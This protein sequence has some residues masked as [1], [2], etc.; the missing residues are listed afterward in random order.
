MKIS[1]TV[2]LSFAMAL[3]AFAQT[4]DKNQSGASEVAQD[5]ATDDISG[6]YS[7]LKEGEFVQLTVEDGTRVSGF[8]SRYGE[9]ESDKGAFLDQ[10]IKKGSREGK[11]LS[12][13][14][15]P[16]HG[17]WYEFTGTVERGTAK[18][19]G[20]E[21]YWLLLGTLTRHMA[22]IKHKETVS[23]RQVTFKSFPQDSALDQAK[24]D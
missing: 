23:S 10:F 4:S 6:M 5:Q 2:L 24:R 14:C 18:T 1:L 3:C 8:I 12:F 17:I 13:S 9:L 15:E 21:G 11:R 7:F 19:H 22:D 20:E 16:V